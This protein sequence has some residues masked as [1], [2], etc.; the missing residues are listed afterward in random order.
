MKA[1]KKTKEMLLELWNIYKE[2]D[3][4]ISDWYGYFKEMIGKL[5]DIL[6]YLGIKHD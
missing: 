1:D 5:I 2:S 3:C 4:T 6:D